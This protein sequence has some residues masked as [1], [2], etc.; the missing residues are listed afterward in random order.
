MDDRYYLAAERVAMAKDFDKIEDS[1]W[2]ERLERHE[3]KRWVETGEVDRPPRLQAG[4]WG[5]CART[6]RPAEGRDLRR[7]ISD[8]YEHLKAKGYVFPK[9]Y[10]DF[11]RTRGFPSKR[12]PGLTDSED[13]QIDQEVD[14]FSD[15]MA[16]G[17]AVS[18][19]Y[20]IASFL[21]DSPPPDDE[22]EKRGFGI[23]VPQDETAAFDLEAVR[24]FE[25]HGLIPK[26]LSPRR[27]VALGQEFGVSGAVSGNDYGG[28]RWFQVRAKNPSPKCQYCGDT[29]NPGNEACEFGPMGNTFTGK[30]GEL[31]V[32]ETPRQCE[33]NGCIQARLG[34]APVGRPPKYC[35]KPECKRA[36]ERFKKRKDRAR[37]AQQNQDFQRDREHRISIAG[38]SAVPREAPD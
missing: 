32:D 34:T 37:K 25:D 26:G 7:R 31:V 14:R 36:Y 6:G 38:S 11:D 3:V 22:P 10:D 13:D 35:G 12:T 4:L 18:A 19:R 8:P 27:L 2:P 23:G 24:Q 29:L 21:I 30:G 28:S 5:H 15:A 17:G 9:E 20:V 1:R 16:S 33:C